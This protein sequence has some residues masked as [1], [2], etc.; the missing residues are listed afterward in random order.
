MPP[1]HCRLE[2][3]PCRQ[4]CLGRAAPRR[5]QCL[6][7]AAPREQGPSAPR[8]ERAPALAVGLVVGTL[9]GFCVGGFFWWWINYAYLPWW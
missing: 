6:G 9:M 5:Q 4:Q 7:R 2:G 1:E 3:R 8:E